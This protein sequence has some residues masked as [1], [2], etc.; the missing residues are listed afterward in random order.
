MIGLEALFE[1]RRAVPSAEEAPKEFVR[2]LGA[3]H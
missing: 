3:P 1:E 2:G